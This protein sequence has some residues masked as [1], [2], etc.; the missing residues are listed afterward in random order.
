MTLPLIPLDF[1]REKVGLCMIVKNE[2]R[3][4]NRCLESVRGWVG[5]MVVV[6][7][8]STDETVAIALAHGARVSHFHWC[9]D[10]SAAR[11]AALNQ[12]SR[13]WVLVLDGDETC[14]VDDPAQLANALQQSQWD[15]FSLPISS[16]NDDGTSSKAMVFR[17]FRRTPPGMRYRGEIH[18]Q[19]EAV[20]D[21]MV[22]TS[23]LSCIRLEHDGYTAA[24]VASG[25]KANR[26]IRLSR[27]V[28]QSRPKDPFSWF[29]YAMAI[30]QSDPDGMLDAAQTA[31]E[32]MD[33]EPSRARGE[34]YVV[35]LYLAAI[36]VHQSRGN[37]V[38]VI[39][40]ANQALTMF[41]D[42]PDLHYQRGGARIA[43][44]DFAGAVEDFSAALSD[45]AA[46][47]KLVIDPAAAGFGARTRLGCSLR[48]LGRSDEAIAQ[49]R[50]ATILAPAD[51]ADAHAE[52]GVVFMERGAIEEAVP[53]FE[54]AYRRDLTAPGVAFKLGWCLYKL[55]R[56]ERAEAVLRDQTREPQADL[57]LA[58]VL[59]DTGRAELALALLAENELPASLLTLGWTHFVLGHLELAGRAWDAWLAQMPDAN[60]SKTALLLFRLLLGNVSQAADESQLSCDSPRE[61]DAW[62]LLLLR[63]QRSTHIDEIIRRGPLLGSTVWPR[64]RMRWAQAMVVDGFVDSGMTLLFDAAREAPH[65]DAVYYWLG[66]CAALRQQPDDALVMFEE[67]LRRNPTHPQVRQAMALLQ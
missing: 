13:E 60:S 38:Q 28:T 20:A 51:Y 6:D 50:T 49:L 43:V 56:F 63:Y 34:H 33:A 3:A 47:F 67:C 11:N 14:M 48:H 24:V 41:P 16:L 30:A 54:E 1:P 23:T 61:M 59:L 21:G 39:G 32:L 46:A 7:T 58:R 5:E 31:F 44:G 19:L 15:G 62:V 4:L 18:E 65:D 55:A 53:F 9:D 12:A 27:K 66:Y 25:D 64:L 17:L 40:M 26:N 22:E 37:V 2:A 57:L 36:N 35:N 52:L 29:V 10:F 42:S 8:G 45:S